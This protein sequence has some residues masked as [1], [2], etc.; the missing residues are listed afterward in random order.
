VD[1]GEAIAVTEDER[2]FGEEPPRRGRWYHRMPVI[3]TATHER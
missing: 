3:S 1:C 2:R